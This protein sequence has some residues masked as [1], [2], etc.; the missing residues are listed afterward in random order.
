V[1]ESRKILAAH[2]VNIDVEGEDEPAWFD[3]HL[4]GRVLRHLLENAA[5]YTPRE[6]AL[7]SRAGGRP[8]RLEFS[9]SRTMGRASIRWIF[10]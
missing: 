8:E 4:L 10:R 6:A 1:E 7:R 5:R 3:P 9:V 2:R